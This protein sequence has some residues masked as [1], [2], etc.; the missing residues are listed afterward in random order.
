M[1]VMRLRNK[2]WFWVVL[3]PLLVGFV[4]CVS[5][6]EGPITAERALVRLRPSQYPDFSDDMTYES[7]KPALDQSLTYLRRLDPAAEFR[8]GPDT[9]TAGHLIDSIVDFSRLIDRQISDETLARAIRDDY[10]VY[11]SVGY[12]GDGEVLFTGYYEPVLKGSLAPSPQFPYPIYRCPDDLVTV[13]LGLFDSRYGSDRLVGRKT[14]QTVVP[15]FDREAIDSARRLD[16]R[17]DELVWISSRIDVFFLQIQGSGRVVLEDGTVLHVNYACGNGRPYR[18]IGKLLIEEGKIAR[19]DMS[20]QRIRAYLKRHPEEMDGILNHN[21]SYVFFRLVDA[22]PLG[23]LEVPLTG[24][25]CIAT[26][27]DLFPPGAL[28]FV[29]SEKPVTA[30][31]DAV[32]SWR[33]FTRFVLN[34]DRGGAIRGAGR[35]DLF[36]GNGAYARTAAGHM[37]QKGRLYFVVKKENRS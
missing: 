21:P 29:E 9:Y 15:Y 25:R 37:Q 2:L 18:S 4:G 7:L 24:G 33:P 23:A 6:E 30:A 26:D 14:G 27:L 10:R 13:D 11:R 19:E 16:N 8:F 1:D 20:A 12:D 35:V 28:A 32:D 22:G 3:C 31:D 34:Q 5:Q 17:G 36:W